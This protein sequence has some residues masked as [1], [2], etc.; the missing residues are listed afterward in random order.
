MLSVD[1]A[2][3]TKTMAE[4]IWETSSSGSFSLFFLNS[5]VKWSNKCYFLFVCFFVKATIF[6]EEK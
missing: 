5:T 1:I 6:W 2:P 4:H 3:P